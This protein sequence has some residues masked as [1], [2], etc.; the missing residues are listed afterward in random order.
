MP[1]IRSIEELLEHLG[2]V[3]GRDRPMILHQPF[4]LDIVRRPRRPD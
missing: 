4:E 3:V 2:E 1:E